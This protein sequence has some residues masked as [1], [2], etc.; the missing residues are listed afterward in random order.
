MVKSK[1]FS[2]FLV[3]FI[4]G[5]LM[6]FAYQ[7]K[8]EYSNDEIRVITPNINIK[9]S[10]ADYSDST[11]CDQER[12]D[13]VGYYECIG[14]CVKL[15]QPI[16]DCIEDN[17]GESVTFG[18]YAYYR[19]SDETCSQVQQRGSEQYACLYGSSVQCIDSDGQNQETKGSVTYNGQT[20]TDYCDSIS[21]IEYYCEPI[22]NKVNHKSV[23]CNPDIYT[24]C[25]DGACVKKV[26]CT[27]SV[28]I[29]NQK[30]DNCNSQIDEGLNCG[31]TTTNT[32]Q[33]YQE[34]TYPNCKIS[35]MAYVIGGI[36]LLLFVF[37]V[38][39]K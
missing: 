35:T 27:P 7:S 5:L 17:T 38:M 13:D 1:N 20:Y 21:V 23:W 29:C 34:G 39:R 26:A 3:L 37:M 18:Y 16:V 14:S 15:T 2:F 9:Y 32:C 25:Q 6:L 8:K 22:L 19:D 36:L 24:S 28:E 12:S 4:I 11:R 30:D 10:I 31:G 33:F